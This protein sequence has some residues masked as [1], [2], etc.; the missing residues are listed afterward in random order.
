MY[1]IILRSASISYFAPLLGSSYHECAIRDIGKTDITE[2]G[3]VCSR[4]LARTNCTSIFDSV[5]IARAI[6]D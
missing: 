3:N 2:N 6:N 5:N 4:L 1:N